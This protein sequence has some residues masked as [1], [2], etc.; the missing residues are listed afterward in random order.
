MA[1][2]LS[3]GAGAGSAD[4]QVVGMVTGLFGSASVL[5]PDGTG[6][7]PLALHN[8]V[9]E[10]DTVRTGPGARL[11]IALRDDPVLSLGADGEL[12]LDRSA[13]LS[14]SPSAICGR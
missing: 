6:P 7:A 10:G 3:S 1:V 12:K 2:L 9:H 11:R 13:Q 14:R 8:E 5:R 4:A